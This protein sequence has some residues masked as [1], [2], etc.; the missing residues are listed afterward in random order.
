MIMPMNDQRMAVRMTP[1]MFSRLFFASNS[2]TI[3]ATAIGSPS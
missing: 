1:K 2:A 3:L